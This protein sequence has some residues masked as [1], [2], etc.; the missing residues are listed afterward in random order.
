MRLLPPATSWTRVFGGTAAGIVFCVA[1]ALFVDS[2]NF[3][4]MSDEA[5]LRAIVTDL[6][7]PTLLAGPLLFLLLW[8]MR[9]LAIAHRE[10]TELAT[11][12]SLTA[13]L[14]RGAFKMLVDA[15]LEQA[16]VNSRHGALLIVDADHFKSINDQFGH[17]WGD[18]ALQLIAAKIFG[19][20]KAPDLVGRIGGEEFGIFLQS[21]DPAQAWNVAERI[22]LAVN[23]TEIV[24]DGMART[25]SVSVGG[26][27][28]AAGDVSYDEVFV[29]ADRQL[30]RAKWSGRNRVSLASIGQVDGPVRRAMTP[31]ADNDAGSDGQPTPAQF[32]TTLGSI[33]HSTRTHLNMQVAYIA[34]FVGDVMVYRSL[35]G[36]DGLPIH[37][38]SSLPLR[39]A[40]GPGIVDGTLPELMP[41]VCDHPAAADKP[42]TRALGSAPMSECQFACPMATST[43]CSAASAASPTPRS[44]SA[45]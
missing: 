31:Y 5:R 32:Q 44:T 1:V 37:E 17:D 34:E 28:F 2:F 39:D 40:Y 3:A 8:K 18:R 42:F 14:N 10:M 41:D 12:D 22:R 11:M 35:E 30:Y 9:Q 4:Y 26:A 27:T 25:L 36:E 24:A 45:T 29:L 33:L 13:V 21:A 38:G 6:L 43:A 20:V 16:A 7:L 15:Y 19:E 23:H